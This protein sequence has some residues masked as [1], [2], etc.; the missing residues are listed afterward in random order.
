MTSAEDLD[1]QARLHDAAA[2]VV[3]PPAPDVRARVLARIASVSP[4]DGSITAP[5]PARRA[6]ARPAV[7]LVR[8]LLLAAAL[9]LVGAGVAAALGYR[10]PG[11]DLVFGEPPPSVGAG[12]DLGSPL[13][14]R[15]ALAVDRPRVLAPGDL[16]EP[17]GAW[18]LGNGS[19]RIVTLGWRADAG[20]P[21]LAGSDLALTV[22][23]VPGDVNE[24]V[25]RKVVG[26]GTTI[27]AV[28]VNGDRGWWI[29]GAPHEIM[30]LRPDG[31]AGVLRS[32]LAGDSLVFA[33]D[34]TLYRLE[35][36]LGRDA[37]LGIAASMR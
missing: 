23:A 18:V 4:G 11:F 22:M 26:E 21:A 19:K 7:R 34:G 3:W 29:A 8:V 33:R 24:D 2:A 12:L 28:T 30:I 25:I 16:R 5:E 10:L 14:L 20:R 17:D 1:L 35:S 9:V 15:D 27:D 32:A 31:T 6:G 36:A 37:T 13:S